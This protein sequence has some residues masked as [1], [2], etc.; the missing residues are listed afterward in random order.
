MLCHAELK[1]ASCNTTKRDK[2]VDWSV[3]KVSE[4]LNDLK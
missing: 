3:K 4:Y 2:I 1:F